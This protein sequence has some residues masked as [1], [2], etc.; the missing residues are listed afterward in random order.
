MKDTKLIN[1]DLAMFAGTVKIEL[2]YSLK[3]HLLGEIEKI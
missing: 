2:S 1:S 3:I